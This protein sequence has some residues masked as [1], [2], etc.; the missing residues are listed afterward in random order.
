[1]ATKLPALRAG[2]PLQPRKIPGTHF[3]Q[4][5]RRPQ[6]HSADGRIRSIEKFNDLIGSRTRDI[7]ACSIVLQPTSLPRAPPLFYVRVAINS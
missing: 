3:C 4:K 7:T 1:M 5:L 2:R 6:G